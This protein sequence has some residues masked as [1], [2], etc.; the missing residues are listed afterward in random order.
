M[1]AGLQVY[2]ANGTLTLD[3]N[4]RHGRLLGITQLPLTAGSMSVP[5]LS[6]GLPWANVL[7]PAVN[8]VNGLPV[9]SNGKYLQLPVISFSGTTLSWTANNWQCFVLY[10]VY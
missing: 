6:Q 1:A 3:T 7:P 9:G 5:A 8:Y 4:T 10:G 2:A